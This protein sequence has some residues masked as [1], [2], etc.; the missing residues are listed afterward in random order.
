MVLFLGFYAV[1]TSLQAKQFETT[2]EKLEELANNKK[3]KKNVVNP[4]LTD[5]AKDKQY[6]LILTIVRSLKVI[7]LTTIW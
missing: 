7:D 1:K 6:A 3:K 2:T 5:A 4:D